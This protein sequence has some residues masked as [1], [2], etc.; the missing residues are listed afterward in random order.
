LKFTVTVRSADFASF[1]SLCFVVGNGR[2]EFDLFLR[3]TACTSWARTSY[4]NSVC[5]SWCLSRPSTDPSPSERDS[6]FSPYDSA[7]SLVFL[8]PNFVPMGEEI[9]LQRGRQKGVPPKNPYFTSINSSSMRTA[10][11]RHKLVAYHNKHCWRAF[12]EYE[13]R[14]P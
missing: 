6:G 3:A 12:R 7:E 2:F 9:L 14:W 1:I 5:L 10:A 4:R 11:D 8:V 13:H